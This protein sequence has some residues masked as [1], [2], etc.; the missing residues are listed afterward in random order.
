MTSR[1]RTALARV[2]IAIAAVSAASPATTHAWD[3]SRT[4]VGI[5]ERAVASHPVHAQWMRASNGRLGWFTALRVDPQTLDPR[6]RRLLVA[7]MRVAHPDVGAVAP[8]GPGACPAQPAPSETLQRC[9]DGDAWETSALGWLRVGIALAAA[10]RT[11]LLH[12]FVDRDDPGSATWTARG[13]SA[14]TWRR[15]ARRAGGS[16]AASAGR[17]GFAG[18]TQSAGAWLQSDADPFGPAALYAHQRAASL[19]ATQAERDRHRALALVCAGVLLHLVQDLSLP[20]HARGDLAGTLVPLSDDRSDRGSPLAEYARV[21]FGRTIPLAIELDARAAEVPAPANLRALLFGDDAHEGLATFAGSRFLSDGSMPMP[22]RLDPALDPAA[23]AARWL[24][25]EGAGLAAEEREG[26]VLT[27]W[28]ASSGYLRNAQGR[29]LAAFGVDDDGVVRGYLDRRVLREQAL[30]L[31]PAAV[32]ATNDAMSLV[33]PAWPTTAFDRA[34]DHIEIE[35]DV[36]LAKAEVLVVVEDAQGRRTVARR[37]ALLAERSRIRDVTPPAVPEGARVVL[38]L[39]G[40]RHDGQRVVIEQALAS[41]D[42]EVPAARRADAGPVATD[43]LAEPAPAPDATSP[44]STEPAA[45][46]EAATTSPTKTEP[47]ADTEPAATSR[48]DDDA[49][50]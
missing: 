50:P 5:T 6:M 7:G 37:V 18:T 15:V 48:D 4:H 35:P 13:R 1:I 29:A 2:A 41:V 24:G 40:E 26:A 22:M 30:Q 16:L 36:A 14:V 42:A 20:A 10:D 49:P 8:G 12:H 34:A 28:P 25:P 17:T 21:T 44:T 31:L 45:S 47:A 39:V 11:R 9:V 3:P 32:E 23:A 43:P 38:V 33:W 46:T 19:A 27:P